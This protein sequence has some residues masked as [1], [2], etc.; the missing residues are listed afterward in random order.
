MGSNVKISPQ[1]E[2]RPHGRR[3]RDREGERERGRERVRNSKGQISGQ[4]QPLGEWSGLPV[5][6]HPWYY[7]AL[8]CFG[9]KSERAFIIQCD[10]Y[11]PRQT[12][13]I[14]LSSAFLLLSLC[15]LPPSHVP[16]ILCFF[17]FLI[18]APFSWFIILITFL[19]MPPALCP[20]LCVV[21][22]LLLVPALSLLLIPLHLSPALI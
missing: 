2:T 9:L 8:V 6:M 17:V 18:L 14:W 19:C 12:L 3:E 20:L 1:T 15:S 21:L 11:H 13:S 4:G 22:V 10:W 5:E 16:F 7:I